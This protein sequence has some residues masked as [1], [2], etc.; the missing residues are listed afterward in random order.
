M[1]KDEI[2]N[3][4]KETGINTWPALIGYILGKFGI[5][6]GAVLALIF[7][8]GVAVSYMW[9]DRK[10][11]Y[12]RHYSDQNNQ[13]ES[14]KQSAKD[15]TEVIKQNAIAFEKSAGATEDLSKAVDSLRYEIINNR[16]QR[17][18]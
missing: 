10:A 6:I 9:E 5:G 1:S 3:E 4:M 11:L 15:M 13:I 14:L 17:G 12:E 16:N 8:L 2:L 18:N 7:V